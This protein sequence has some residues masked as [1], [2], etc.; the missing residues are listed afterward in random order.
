MEK[1]V[2]IVSWNE[3]DTLIYPPYFGRCTSANSALYA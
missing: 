3:S 2:F 1:T